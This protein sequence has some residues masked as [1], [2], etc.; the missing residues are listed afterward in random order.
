[1]K[2]HILGIGGTFMASIAILAKK[3]GFEVTGQDYKIYPPMSEQLA[4][5]DIT[6]MEGFEA[7]LLPE[8]IDVIIVGNVMTRKMSAIEYILDNDIPFVSGPEFLAKY[9]L[10][11]KHVLAV[12][13]THG[14][15]TTASMLAW[16]L[17]YAGLEPG[18]LIGGVPNNFGIS[19]SLGAGQFFVV[20]GDEYDSAFFDK[21][22]KFVHYRPK[23]LII[24]NIEYD[25]ADI[26]ADLKAILTQF[27]H[28]VRVVASNGLIIY[29]DEDPNIKELLAM[30][31]WTSTL[32][33][34]IDEEVDKYLPD[35]IIGEHNQK[36]ALAA[37]A[38]AANIGISR[39]I[40]IAALADFKGVKR[41][42]ELKGT[43]KSITIYSDFAH[44][45]TAIKS[46]L[47][48]LR[49]KI[50]VSQR[51][52]AIIDLCS[53][54]M[55]SGIHKDTLSNSVS[56]ADEVYFY[57]SGELSWDVEAMWSASHRPGGVFSD[58]NILLETIMKTLKK[59]DQVLLMSNGA[60]A[61]FANKLLFKLNPALAKVAD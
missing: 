60:F 8:D 54:T 21:R 19:A 36:N 4:H 55:K 41:R 1:M 61:E 40:S 53:N 51:I 26:F 5:N 22:S 47:S 50:D 39:E 25:H 18:Y 16:I 2:V 45:P 14:K 48:G 37:I 33:F 31:C 3:M 43:A 32:P 13:G 28:L 9:I 6:V 15:T 23:T 57:H 56:H 11:G 49:S 42:L 44:H 35:N 46:T 59:G 29:A 58:Q 34:S 52:I 12:T 27:H 24:N 10:P 17:E 20:E 7:E 38:A 30:G